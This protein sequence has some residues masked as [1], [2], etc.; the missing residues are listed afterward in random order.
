MRD[1]VRKRLIGV[2][3]G[4]KY[5][6]RNPTTFFSKQCGQ[7]RLMGAEKK[8]KVKGRIR[9]GEGSRLPKLFL[10]SE[11]VVTGRMRMG[12]GAGEEGRPSLMLNPEG[13]PVCA[14]C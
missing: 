3:I 6:P 5:R 9:S 2:L 7:R 12:E 8:N 14:A 4:T 13:F 10:V 11:S 1:G